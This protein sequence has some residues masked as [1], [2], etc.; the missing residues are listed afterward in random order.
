MS[1]SPP[2]TVLVAIARAARRTRIESAV[3]AAPA[4]RL[5]RAPDRPPADALRALR[6]DVAVVDTRRAPWPDDALAEAGTLLVALT[7]EPL[8]AAG[9]VRGVLP[10][11]A[12]PDAV[13]AAVIAVAAGLVVAHPDLDT[14][15]RAVS[16]RDAGDRLEPLTAREIDVLRTLGEGLGN[17]A[18]AARLGISPHTAKFHVASILGKLGAGSRTEAVAIGIRRG[19]VAI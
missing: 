10:T 8:R 19:L 17:K 18:I 1:S 14:R 9:R 6:P 3:A 2:I 13:V 15:A 7:H 16:R 11:D 5:V 12:R 4:L